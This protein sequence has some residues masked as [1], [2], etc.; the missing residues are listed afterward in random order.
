MSSVVYPLERP[1]GSNGLS[2]SPM[3]PHMGLVILN[4]SQFFLKR[5]MNVGKGIALRRRVD[6]GRREMSEW[7]VRVIRMHCIHFRYCQRTKGNFLKKCMPL[8][9]LEWEHFII[10]AASTPPSIDSRLRMLSRE[11]KTW[12]QQTLQGDGFKASALK[13]KLHHWSHLF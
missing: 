3:V 13:L 4:R 6:N 9:L 8:T 7:R 1:P 2:S 12:Q 11:M 5:E 10:A